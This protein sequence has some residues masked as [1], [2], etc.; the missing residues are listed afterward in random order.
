VEQCHLDDGPKILVVSLTADVTGVDSVLRQRPCARRILREKQVSVVMK[1]ADDRS[2]QSKPVQGLDDL[3]NRGG[4]RLIVDGDTHQLAARTGEVR[5]LA[6]GGLNVSRVGV[7][8]R[9]D[10][11]RMIRTNRDTTY[12]GGDCAPAHRG[13]HELKYRGDPARRLIQLAPTSRDR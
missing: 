3:R 8:H 10:H 7:G 1:V 6:R 12:E 11:N 5:H 2:R 4:R 13:R 9:L